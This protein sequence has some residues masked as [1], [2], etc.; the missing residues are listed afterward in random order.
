MISRSVPIAI[1]VLAFLL[2]P[3]QASGQT[4]TLFPTQA[5]EPA[6][7]EAAELAPAVTDLDLELRSAPF[8]P[9]PEPE[10]TQASDHRSP[11][12]A[13]LIEPF[14][15]TLGYAYAGDWRRGL[16]PAGVRVVGVGLIVHGLS[17]ATV[18]GLFGGDADCGSQ[19][20]LGLGMFMVGT[21]WGTVG[22]ARTA[23]L[24]NRNVA[25]ASISLQPAWVGEG[26]GVAAR[27]RF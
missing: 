5:P 22:A 1:L 13:G 26:P 14:V 16:L 15:P 19:C 27:V 17:K 11:V 24:H 3:F 4:E 10:A 21:V 23:H 6:R 12:V 25:G 9:D 2:S 20:S 8:G 18:D 7:D